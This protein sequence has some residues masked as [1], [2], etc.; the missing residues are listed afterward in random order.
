MRHGLRFLLRF[1]AAGSRE[2][3]QMCVRIIIRLFTR[4]LLECYLHYLFAFYNYL[5]T[6]ITNKNAEKI[7]V[8]SNVRIFYL[9]RA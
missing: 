4:T 6:P 8:D 7:V 5:V 1:L 9:Y 3:I 2:I